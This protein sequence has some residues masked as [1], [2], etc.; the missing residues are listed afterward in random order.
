M[1][2][3]EEY[4][5]DSTMDI[6]D[7]LL[8]EDTFLRMGVQ[9][10]DQNGFG[11]HVAFEHNE[12]P[13][14]TLDTTGETEEGAVTS[15]LN[16]STCED[17]LSI[18]MDDPE[19]DGFY[20]NAAE[21]SLKVHSSELDTYL[22]DSDKSDHTENTCPSHNE[23]VTISE[24][25]ELTVNE[26]ESPLHCALCG[27]LYA[28]PRIL[29]CLHAYCYQCIEKCN[30]F[31]KNRP[32]AK[33][34]RCPNCGA[35]QT[36]KD[37][38]KLPKHLVLEQLVKL[39]DSNAMGVNCVV[40]AL[41][42]QEREPSGKCVDCGDLLCDS[43]C[44]KHTFS[45]LTAKHVIVPL[46][47]QCTISMR[48]K[49]STCP[50]HEELSLS[51][52][53]KCNCAVCKVCVREAHAGHACISLDKKLQEFK[54]DIDEKM[55][56]LEEALVLVEKNDS[57][58]EDL[59]MLEKLEEE[60]LDV[61]RNGRE[62]YIE[63]VVDSYNASTRKLTAGYKRAKERCINRTGFIGARRKDLNNIS[64]AVH[65]IFSEGRF[66][67]VMQMEKLL[68]NRIDNVKKNVKRTHNK[69]TLHSNLPQAE[70]CQELYDKLKAEPCF[71]KV[72]FAR[73]KEKK[74]KGH[75][76]DKKLVNKVGPRL[77]C[78]SKALGD[79][80]AKALGDNKGNV[81]N[82]DVPQFQNQKPK[83][84]QGRGALLM[85][86]RNLLHGSTSRPLGMDE[87]KHQSRNA[88]FDHYS[89]SQRKMQSTSF[90][91][92]GGP[93]DRFF[94]SQGTLQSAPFHQHGRNMGPVHIHHDG[95][96]Q[97]RFFGPNS[98]PQNSSLQSAP[99][100]QGGRNMG[101]VR[102]QHSGSE[103][104][105]FFGP[106]SKANNGS[107]EQPV[108]H[109][110]NWCSSSN[111]RGSLLG[112]YPGPHGAM[113]A[114]LS[115][116]QQK[117]FEAARV[118]SH[119]SRNVFDNFA[120]DQL[121]SYEHVRPRSFSGVEFDRQTMLTSSTNTLPDPHM[122]VPVFKQRFAVDTHIESD[123]KLPEIK[124]IVFTS[125]ENFVVSDGRNQML[126]AFSCSGAY[127]GLHC[128][129]GAHVCHLL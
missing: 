18:P 36:V 50:S 88:D 98:K 57:C 39:N 103:Q 100:H 55:S 78:Q 107:L 72:E 9:S 79:N 93:N 83:V 48:S 15:V 17:S 91:Q 121:A 44:E 43:C 20:F 13:Q 54:K 62:K 16:E 69:V 68:V 117:M 19:K 127:L 65:F 12:G 30:Y 92:G 109:T 123:K 67:E 28:D 3:Q 94:G 126:K 1:I 21:I 42:E 104:D 80:K 81:I 27:N 70:M 77:N 116:T 35:F 32:T 52:C 124:G 85:S 71:F 122:T 63:L 90:H 2:E 97:D 46:D 111:S 110:S 4:E 37:S 125:S 113:S 5:T 114:S 24:T 120:D 6:K 34:L 47:S 49:H 82:R 29:D 53:T 95:G 45:R 129:P 22:S 112:D 11:T 7:D 59:D 41:H 23:E 84:P 38:Q 33:L 31:D 66:E 99:L 105:Q 14:D 119:S 61:L 128:G 64:K 106:H 108:G 74:A 86:Y 10:D 87:N 76:Q 96:E 51:F 58:K 102:V 25:E 75:Q 26:T 73:Q 89:D 56:E 40:C 115:A 118:P 8:Q 101:P 60:Q